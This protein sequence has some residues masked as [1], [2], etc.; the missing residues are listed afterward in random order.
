MI[1][2]ARREEAGKIRRLIWQAHLNPTGLDWRRFWVAADEDGQILGCAQIRPHRDGSRE[3]ASLVVIPEA[4]GKGFAR[5]LIEHFLSLEKPPLYLRCSATL[6][7]LYERFG[8]RVIE[9]EEI[10]LSL[11]RSWQVMNWVKNHL[12][13]NIPGMLV[14]RWG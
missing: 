3:L 14:M 2:P 4:R 12:F 1:R 5:E 7:G 8:F 13:R 11:R 9:L 10:P 6:Q